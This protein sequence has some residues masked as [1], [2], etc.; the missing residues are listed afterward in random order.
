M[1]GG[2]QVEGALSVPELTRL[3]E[4]EGVE[5]IIVTAEDLSRYRGVKLAGIAEVRGRE[6]LMDAQRELATVEGVTVLIH[7]QECAAELRRKRK[8]GKAP[9]PPERIHI[10]E[11]VC[12]GCGDCGRKSS[13]LSVVPID[14][15]FGRKTQIHQSSCNKD[16]SCLEGDCPSFLT[17]VPGEREEHAVPEP[18]AA[19]PEPEPLVGRGRL[20]GQDDGDRRH[21]GRHGQ[22]DPR[23]GGPHRW[24]PRDRPRPDR[25]E[26]EGRPGDLGPS[27]LDHR[28]GRGRQGLDRRHGP[29]PRI[30]PARR[31]PAG[32]PRGRRPRAHGRGGLDQR[33]ADREDGR[34]HRASASPSSP[35][36]ST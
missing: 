11:R 27:D 14:T 17:V 15:E 28:R 18:P 12:E 24:A 2:Q 5:R 3:L 22:P 20:H 34:R 36:S 1:T 23:G 21:R 8:R 6:H 35:A 30:R 33:G 16:Y 13:C 9:D 31:R 7:D 25:A 4:L 29:L 19:L 32:Q 10:N 26:P